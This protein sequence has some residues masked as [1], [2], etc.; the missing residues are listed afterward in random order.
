MNLFAMSSKVSEWA[1]ERTNERANEASSAQQAHEW[2]VRVKSKRKSE[3][4]S[5]LRVDF[6]VILPNLRPF[7]DTEKGA[8]RTQGIESG[9]SKQSRV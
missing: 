8:K 4:P 1:S 7:D 9:K 5:T 6:T 3:W 2:A